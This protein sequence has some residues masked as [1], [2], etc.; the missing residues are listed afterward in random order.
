MSIDPSSIW[1][2]LRRRRVFRAAAIYAALTWV[3]VQIAD[4]VGP[5]VNFPDRYMTTLVGIAIAGFPITIILAWLFDLTPDGVRRTK[6][7]S[8]TGVLAIV[9]SL[10]LLAAGTAGFVWLIKPGHDVAPASAD[11][12]MLADSIAVLPFRD[13]SPDG[14]SQHFADGIAEV[15]IH[16]LSTI[17]KIK[18]IASDSSFS[19]RDRAT[20]FKS[21]GRLLGVE[22]VLV[23]SVQRSGD[24]LRISTQLIDSRSGESVWTQL[25][26]R[27]AQDVFAI[28]EEIA[29]AVADSLD[30]VI[31]ATTR[32]RVRRPITDNADA[33]DLYTLA[34][35]RFKTTPINDGF[36][37]VIDLLEQSLELDPDFALSWAA[38]AGAV[39]WTIQSGYIPGEEGI[40][41][42]R[43]YVAKALELDPELSD[44][45]AHMINLH[46]QVDRD[47]DAARRS[48]EKAIEYG[49]SNSQAYLS[50][51]NILSRQDKFDEAVDV[52]LKG[53]ELDPVNPG[54]WLLA[55]LGRAYMQLGDYEL[56]MQQYAAIVEQGRGTNLE[57]QFLGQFARA[58]KAYWRFDEAVAAYTIAVDKDFGS[59]GNRTMLAICLIALRDIDEAEV[60]L[61]IAE[62]ML[63]EAI[64]QGMGISNRVLMAEGARMQLDLATENIE[65]LLVSAKYFTEIAD[66][67]ADDGGSRS[68]NAMID[69]SYRWLALGRYDEV[70]RLMTRFVEVVPD[71]ENYAYAVFAN[72]KIGNT[73]L[74]KQLQREGRALL[75]AQLEAQLGNQPHSPDDLFWFALFEAAVGKEDQAIEYLQ[76]AYAS[77]FLDYYLLIYIPLFDEFRSDPRFVAV[78]ESMLHDTDEMRAR[79]DAVRESGDWQSLIAKYFEDPDTLDRR[80]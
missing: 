2:D 28:Q 59:I 52:Y 75:E 45:H 51:G 72:Y 39:Y 37:E 26:D 63:D 34:L 80:E 68:N 66:A 42:S 65:G 10:T 47:F 17:E 78:L 38:L 48:F 79:V 57:G 54:S 33:F 43:E 40:S 27:E 67:D 70:A 71:V 32:N 41:R 13:L 8:A 56:G 61:D 77:G 18:V 31:G 15:L 60:Q 22:R 64:A 9:T 44:A 36:I 69:A 58:A 55:N 21:I 35:H 14:K 50:F 19:L 25:F 3:I 74:A 12:E 11:A 6:P 73:E 76:Q 62:A 30:T 24:K 53:I 20:D 5:A 16:Q 23:G 46:G 49:P 4:V 1:R 29:L 7:G